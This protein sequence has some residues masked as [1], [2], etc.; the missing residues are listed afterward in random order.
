MCRQHTH[1]NKSCVVDIFHWSV[2]QTY[3]TKSNMYF[4]LYSHYKSIGYVWRGIKTIFR[5]QKV[6]PCPQVLKFLDPP[7]ILISREKYLYE[8]YVSFYKVT[9]QET[10]SFWKLCKLQND[11]PG[12]YLFENYVSFYKMTPQETISF[13][14]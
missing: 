4:I 7:Q 5:P 2:L 14:R 1:D 12:K 6:I 13:Q 8:N 11:T 3:N 9:P 10:I